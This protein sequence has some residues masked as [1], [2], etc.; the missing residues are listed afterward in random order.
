M[1]FSEA[2][3]KV[4]HEKDLLIQSQCVKPS[5]N[6]PSL[7]GFEGSAYFLEKYYTII[8]SPFPWLTLA[9]LSPESSRCLQAASSSQR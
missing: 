5:Y 9:S 8:D 2:V 4:T 6:F 7:S 1:L 3:R